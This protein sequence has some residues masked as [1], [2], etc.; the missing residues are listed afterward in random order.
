MN[1][2]LDQ[3]WRAIT[4]EK[5]PTPGVHSLQGWA[6]SWNKNGQC[7]YHHWK[8]LWIMIL[9]KIKMTKL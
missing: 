1:D 5:Y 3:F 2:I 9:R 7:Q 6:W 4:R 8:I